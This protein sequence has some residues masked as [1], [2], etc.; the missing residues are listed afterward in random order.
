M[1]W[2]LLIRVDKGDSWPHFHMGEIF[3]DAFTIDERGRKEGR[4]EE[5]RSFRFFLFCIFAGGQEG[6]VNRTIGFEHRL[7]LKRSY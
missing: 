6:E 3:C 7:Q 4:G 5:E 2:N 1:R